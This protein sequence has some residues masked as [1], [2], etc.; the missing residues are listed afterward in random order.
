MN[1]QPLA[2]AKR[3]ILEIGRRMYDKNFVASN[4]GNISCRIGE[5]AVLSTP[6]GVSK[7]FMTEDMLIVSDRKGN[8]LEKSAYGISSEI[9]MHLRAYEENDKI[10]AVTHAHPP[11]AT[12]FA[13]AGLPLE[14]AILPEG[15]VQLGTVPIAKYATPGTGE[16]PDSIAPFCAYYN[17]VLL[18]NHGALTWGKTLFEAYYRLESLEYY[19][20]V[21][22]YTQFILKNA[23]LLSGKQVDA[24]IRTR[25]Q[26]GIAGGGVPGFVSEET[27]DRDVLPK[28]GRIDNG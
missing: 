13:I 1:Y 2:E 6:T 22:M 12:S 8:V 7:G 11:I 18:A 24:L 5:D 9:K 20:Q 19:A 10:M 3:D 15:V 27:N 25:E 17:A 26:L 21:T 14:S 23:N 28:S 4:D 16:V